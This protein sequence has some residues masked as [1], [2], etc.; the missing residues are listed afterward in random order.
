M[1]QGSDRRR[2]Y[3]FAAVVAVLAIVGVY[4]TMR[5]TSSG[6][7]TAEES[8]K[9]G[10]TA[11][12]PSSGA[13]APSATKPA[14]PATPGTF[15]VYSY[16]PLSK[17]KIAASAD[18][19]QRFM[20]SYATYRYDEDPVSYAERLKAFTTNELGQS[21]ARSVTSPAEVQQNKVDQVVSQGSARVKTIRDMTVNSIVWVVAA[22]QRITAKSGPRERTDDYAVTLMQVGDGWR[23]YDLQPAAAGQEGDSSGYGGAG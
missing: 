5:P 17:D 11:S 13:P 7:G 22:T 3:V 15:D 8:M 1:T 4:L 16:L 18:L 21:L 23:V 9:V 6:S 14:G 10:H 19:T 20:L 2:G 12:A